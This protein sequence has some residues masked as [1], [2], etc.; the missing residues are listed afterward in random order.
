MG[1]IDTRL[2]R[3]DD[4]EHL[5]RKISGFAVENHAGHFDLIQH[6]PATRPIEME[7]G[8]TVLAVDDEKSRFGVFQIADGLVLSQRTEFEYF[9]GEQQ[10]ATGDGG[11]R[12]GRLVEIDDIADLAAAQQALKSFLAFLYGPNKLRDRIVCVGFGFDCF[13]FK[14]KPA[15][16]LHS[17]QDVASL[18]RNEVEDSVLLPDSRC[19]HTDYL[20]RY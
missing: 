3:V 7:A 10:N 6:A 5:R 1:F 17:M 14:I 18:K 13:A 16:E 12:F 8:E 15:R 19:K 20:T 2:G 4:D 9:F 11:L